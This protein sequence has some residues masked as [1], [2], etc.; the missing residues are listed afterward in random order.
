MTTTIKINSCFKKTERLSG[1][2]KIEN[3]FF[4]G[5]TFFIHPFKIVWIENEILEIPAVKILISVS[6]RNF[7]KAVDRNKIK[8]R[9]RE[10]YR[11]NK[12]PL[13]Q[14]IES[15][16]KSIIFSI[17]YVSKEICPYHEIENKIKIVLKKMIAEYERF[18]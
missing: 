17:I 8:R 1:K 3:L 5:R 4:N 11:K 18:A 12:I 13:I 14:F 7:K 2:K 16:N 10:A 9:I 15:K 6:K